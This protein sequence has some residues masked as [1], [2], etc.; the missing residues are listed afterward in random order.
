[1]G[2]Y[3]VKLEI[4]SLIP[5]TFKQWLHCETIYDQS[6]IGQQVHDQIKLEYPKDL[7]EDHTQ[8]SA[9]VIELVNCYKNQIIIHVID[10]QSPLGVYKSLRYWAREYPTFV[11]DGQVKIA[12]W[13]QT[14][15][16]QALEARMEA[17]RTEELAIP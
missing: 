12:G 4:L 17:R 15:L 1:M 5:T 2:T 14:A 13:D 6:G 10:P 3:P 9:L 8:L 16:K 11:I 7:L